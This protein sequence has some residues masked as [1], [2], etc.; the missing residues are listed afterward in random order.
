MLS[1]CSFS[2]HLPPDQV[3]TV[4]YSSLA[5]VQLIATQNCSSPVVGSLDVAGF[6]RGLPRCGVRT[7][8]FWVLH[9]LPY[10]ENHGREGRQGSGLGFTV[11]SL[12][13]S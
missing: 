1:L 2:L 10:R 3:R 12:A 9:S 11:L 7:A 6:D 4:F 5:K 13:P 8:D